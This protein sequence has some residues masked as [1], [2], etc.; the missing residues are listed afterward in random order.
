MA[1]NVARIP[2]CQYH[3]LYFRLKFKPMPSIEFKQIKYSYPCND[4]G[5]LF[6]QMSKIGQQE[7]VSSKGNKNKKKKKLVVL[8]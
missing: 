8:E 5:T 2:L 1:K 4:L 6:S 3:E 7:N